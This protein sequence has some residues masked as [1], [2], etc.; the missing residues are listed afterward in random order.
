MAPGLLHD[1]SIPETTFAS[2]PHKRGQADCDQD[3]Q[4]PFGPDHLLEQ[5]VPVHVDELAHTIK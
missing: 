5:L 3:L 1:R 4:L 2:A